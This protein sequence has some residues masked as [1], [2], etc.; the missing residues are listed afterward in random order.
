MQLNYHL[1][2]P[3]PAEKRTIILDTFSILSVPILLCVT[4]P[5]NCRLQEIPAADSLALRS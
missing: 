2:I 3:V 5:A 4:S 1:P